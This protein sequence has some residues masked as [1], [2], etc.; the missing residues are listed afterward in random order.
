LTY[1]SKR[2][3]ADGVEGSKHASGRFPLQGFAGVVKFCKVE[4][5]PL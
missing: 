2:S 5:R 3:L 1:P 4:I